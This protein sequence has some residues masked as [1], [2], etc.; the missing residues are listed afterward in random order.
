MFE[1]LLQLLWLAAEAVPDPRLGGA[2][3][4]AENIIYSSDAMEDEWT[5][6]ALTEADLCFKGSELERIG[7]VTEAVEAALADE[8]CD[9]CE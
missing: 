8:G 1:E 3:V 2:A 9:P 5:S 7:S 6:E 4:E